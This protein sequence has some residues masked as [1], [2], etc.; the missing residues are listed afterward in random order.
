MEKGNYGYGIWFL[1]V[2]KN[3][4]VYRI[5]SDSKHV[6]FNHLLPISPPHENESIFKKDLIKF[7]LG[8]KHG[9]MC[10]KSQTLT[11]FCIMTKIQ[12]AYLPTEF[13]PDLAL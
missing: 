8:I 5:S 7:M 10:L 3:Q 2:C 11:Q 6:L 13:I 12:V 9:S 4:I 1:E